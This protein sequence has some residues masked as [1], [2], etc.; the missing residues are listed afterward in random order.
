MA[1]L[2]RNP[3]DMCVHTFPFDVEANV[4]YG[5]CGGCGISIEDYRLAESERLGQLQRP[6]NTPNTTTTGPTN[7]TGLPNVT[8]WE[9]LWHGRANPR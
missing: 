8:T 3:D 4:P 5:E 1:H 2:T 9:E 7:V 6:L